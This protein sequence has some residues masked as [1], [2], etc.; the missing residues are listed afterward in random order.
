MAD[1][2]LIIE[3]EELLGSELA[4]H[5]Q[6][7]GW[8]VV[9]VRTLEEARGVLFGKMLEPLVVLSDMA[10]PDGN[11]L[12][13]LESARERSLGGEWVLLTAYGTVPDSVR[14]LRLGAYDFLEKPCPHERLDLVVSGA[15]R[16]ARA[17]RRLQDQAAQ[18][19]LRYT[20]EAMKGASAATQQVRA[21]IQKLSQVPLSALVI[22]GET[23]T[24]KGLVAR[25]LHYTG[26]RSAGPLV[27]VNCAAIPQ[28]LL[29]SELFGH[30]AGAFTGAKGRHRGLIEQADG[31][32]L[33]LDEISEL[34]PG[35]QAKLLKAVEDQRIRRV[36]GEQE[37]SVNIQLLAA[38]NQD[39]EARI[40]DGA[41][42]EDLYHRLSVFRLDLPAL[43]T[44]IEDL[45][46]LVPLFIDEFNAK[47]AKRVSVVPTS[48]WSKL[49]SYAWPGN[50][51]ELRNVIE[52]CVM[53]APDD[54]FPE[55]WLQLS[56]R[57]TATKPTSLSEDDASLLRVPLDGSVS[58]D[59]VESLM[60]R[61]AL[62]ISNSNVAAAARRLGITRQTL[63]YRIE[64][65]GLGK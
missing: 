31:G 57:T 29:E 42:R 50:V 28:E 15:A 56:E 13:V 59:E 63:R 20:P 26:Q 18:R 5:Y 9:R 25:V 16:S 58:L 1:T 47:A 34:G 65:Y 40:R 4:R 7:Q 35:L 6:K 41:F 44:R 19:N 62:E 37:I 33:L 45:E 3:D 12:D 52:R 51:R 39:L 48:V 36:G 10:L 46:E 55:E 21:L 61:R 23:G 17:Q 27:E 2:L 64:K 38:S 54:V 8:E 30:E 60:I 14:A 32:T 53:L 22:G 43:R 11:A 24:G 49:R